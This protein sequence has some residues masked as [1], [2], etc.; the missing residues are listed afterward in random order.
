MSPLTD[1]GNLKHHAVWIEGEFASLSG[2]AHVHLPVP[3]RIAFRGL[4]ALYARVPRTTTFASFS[5]TSPTFGN[6]LMLSDDDGGLEE[7]F[8]GNKLFIDIPGNEHIVR[9][10]WDLAERTGCR[11]LLLG[12]RGGTGVGLH[13]RT[14]S[15]VLNSLSPTI[16]GAV[17]GAAVIPAP[18]S[19]QDDLLSEER[20]LLGILTS[21]PDELIIYSLRTHAILKRLPFDLP[22]AIPASDPF[23]VAV[24]NSICHVLLCIDRSSTVHRCS[25][26]PHILNSVTFDHLSKISAP[27]VALSRRVLAYA[28]APV[29]PSASPAPTPSTASPSKVQADISMV[30]EGARNVGVGVWSGV[31]SLLG[32]QR[33]SSSA[34]LFACHLEP[35]LSGE[36]ATHRVVWHHATPGQANSVLFFSRTGNLLAV[37]GADGI[38]VRMFEVRPKGR[39]SKGGLRLTKRDELN[40][41][42]ERDTGS[43]CHWYG[44]QRAFRRQRVTHIVWSADS[45]WA[46][47]VTIRGTLHIC[48]INPYGGLPSG[49]SHL[50]GSG[51]IANMTG[52]PRAPISLS[53]VL[54][55]H[56]LSGITTSDNQSQQRG[57]PIIAT[58]GRPSEPDR[59][60]GEQDIFILNRVTGELILKQCLVRMQS[61]WAIERSMRADMS[62]SSTLSN[63]VAETGVSALSSMM[64]GRVGAVVGEKAGDELILGGAEASAKTWG[65]VKRERE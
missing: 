35:L 46:S 4:G 41:L 24:C 27:H 44:L 40:E 64:R 43:L 25:P 42:E 30:I 36:K 57:A 50:L 2:E 53:P 65:I 31:K 45:K 15:E 63:S 47:A 52:P 23:I 62:L 13:S 5:P 26:A 7:T 20:P 21:R 12:Y 56:M 32:E 61:A 11:L 22:Q 37:T 49:T 9:S 17:I 54:R 18:V 1:D 16:G 58:F 59:E 48:V 60:S 29:P 33:P 10:G 28:S 55:I 19:F 14:S 3:A 34:D 39:Y 38:F 6:N 51:R 8:Y